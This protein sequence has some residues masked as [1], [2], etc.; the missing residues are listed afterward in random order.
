VREI[1]PLNNHGSIQLKF[2][3]N[4][5]RYSFNPLQGANYSNERDL[6]Q[7]KTVAT[8]IRNDILAGYFDPTLSKYKLNPTENTRLTQTA[9]KPS[10]KSLLEV[11][12]AWVDTLDLSPAT[13]ADHYEMIRRM[14]VKARS[15]LTD[16]SWFTNASIAASTFNKRL[17]YL[18][19]CLCWAMTE[20][21]VESNPFE[22][23][24]TRKASK[25]EIKPFTLDEMKTILAAFERQHSHYSPFVQFMF[26]S[27]V[28]TS[29]AI[30]LQWKHIDFDRNE[31][32]IRDSLSKDR[33]GNGYRRVR[34]ETK[35]GS[36]RY[37]TMTG[38]LSNLLSSIKPSRATP[39]DL[40]FK[41]A[42][43]C[44]IDSG[45]FREDWKQLLA[46]LGIEYRKPYTTRHTLLSHAIEQGIPITGVAYIAGH[47]D[48]RMVMQTYGHMINR[49]SLPEISLTSNGKEPSKKR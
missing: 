47:A 37:L 31:V 1:I 3:L 32:V 29:E 30:G 7:A 38:D 20:K 35:S 45:N 4:G 23:V 6:A 9:S 17:G 13:K 15:G 48:T 39:D 36:I 2:T 11:W 21:L 18:K 19:T 10:S 8:R 28:R 12:D 33:T 43:G 5:K 42:R 16:T 27:G 46:D 44:V 14:M 34:K 40:V 41:S 24:K 25:P 26:L 49:P 22:K